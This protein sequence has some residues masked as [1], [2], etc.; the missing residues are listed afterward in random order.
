MTIRDRVIESLSTKPQTLTELSKS[1]AGSERAVLGPLVTE[2]IDSGQILVKEEGR[3]KILTVANP[4]TSTPEP[5]AQL[6]G[7]L[8]VATLPEAIWSSNPAVQNTKSVFQRL[9]S[10]AKKDLVVAEP[11]IDS[12]FVEVLS[13]ELRQLAQ[14]G[15]RILLLTRR[16][17]QGSEAQKAILRMY[18]IFATRRSLGGLLE[19][20]EHWYPFR[21]KNGQQHQFIGLHAK[22]MVNEKEAYLG[23]ANWTEY[24]LGN[25]VEFGVLLSETSILQGLREVISLVAMSAKRVDLAKMHQSTT[26]RTRQR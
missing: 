15:G 23:S 19:V 18:E 8:L 20:Y 1:F 2:M 11:F 25:N 12:F 6:A 10:G 3:S 14:R 9:I 5:P 13:E 22:V 7:D 16:I 17:D 24:S 4:L 26:D 21:G